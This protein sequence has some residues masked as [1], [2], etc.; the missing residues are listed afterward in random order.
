MRTELVL[1]IV[2][3]KFDM[4]IMTRLFQ[5]TLLAAVL[6]LL[7]IIYLY[8][9]VSNQRPVR[10]PVAVVPQLFVTDTYISHRRLGNAMFTLA[11]TIG[12]A[13]QNNM[14]PIVDRLS[15]LVD[16]FGIVER[17]AGDIDNA[18]AGA[19]VV[20]YQERKS[21]A[22]EPA[23]RHLLRNVGCTTQLPC[24]VR[25]RGYFQSWRYFDECCDRVRRNFQFREHVANAADAYLA[26]T[27]GHR[28][29][30]RVGVHVRRGNMVDAYASGYAVAPASY[31]R[32]AMRYFTERYRR[33]QLVVCSDDIAWCRSNLPA[34]VDVT[35]D[36]RL[37][38][39]DTGSPYGDFAVL[40][41]CDHVIVSVGTFGWWAAW[42]ANGTTIYYADWPLPNT[43]LADNFEN[44]DYFPP[45]WIAMS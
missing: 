18:L 33:V 36:V 16:V 13:G 5:A 39:C 41:R 42:L 45:H 29:T 23:T 19:L 2:D 20:T 10:P 6:T 35:D 12:I 40:A 4:A 30:T 27:S 3:T 8:T 11:A 9:A 26:T 37:N 22:Y 7:L 32:S 24:N 17:T 44:Y 1:P 38:F 34:A 21:L 25:L 15:P 14:T 31:F 28:K 43:M